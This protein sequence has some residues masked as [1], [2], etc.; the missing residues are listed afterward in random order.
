MKATDLIIRLQ[1]LVEQV[2]DAEVELYREAPNG[3]LYNFNDINDIGISSDEDGNE[4]AI[5]IAHR[6]NFKL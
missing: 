1:R 3:T 5:Y 4:K 2:G 6:E